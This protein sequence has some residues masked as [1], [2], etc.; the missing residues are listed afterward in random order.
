M[1]R[2]VK[3]ANNPLIKALSVNRQDTPEVEVFARQ[4]KRL[5]ILPAA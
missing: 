3:K 4:G 5:L 1:T 2:L